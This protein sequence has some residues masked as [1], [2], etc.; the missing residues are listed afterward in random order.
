MKKFFSIW[1]NQSKN[2][3]TYYTGKLGELELIGFKNL[4]KKNQKEPDITF[5]VKEDKPK[6]EQP[7][8]DPYKSF[9]EQIDITEDLLD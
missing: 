7:K 3:N 4:N 9:G 2:G 1:E 5:Y 8:E 6:Q